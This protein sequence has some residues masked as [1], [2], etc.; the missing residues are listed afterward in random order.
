[1][2]L[3]LLGEEGRKE[4]LITPAPNLWNRKKYIVFSSPVIGDVANIV[5]FLALD[6]GTN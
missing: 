5:L 6:G 3:S 4:C 1:M 2:T